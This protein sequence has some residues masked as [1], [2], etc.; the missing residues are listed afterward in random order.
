MWYVVSNYNYTLIWQTH[1]YD[2]IS[3]Y[4]IRQAARG[5]VR[6]WSVVLLYQYE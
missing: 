3:I 5:A 4:I 1:R 6:A 2:C